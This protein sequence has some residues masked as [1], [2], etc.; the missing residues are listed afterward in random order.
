MWWM[1]VPA[2]YGVSVNYS[3]NYLHDEY[4]SGGICKLSPDF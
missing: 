3:G 2:L 1:Y 4:T